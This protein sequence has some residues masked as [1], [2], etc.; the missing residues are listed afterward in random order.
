MPHYSK[1]SSINRRQALSLIVGT[2][3]VIITGCFNARISSRK[4]TID[5]EAFAQ[6]VASGDPTAEGFVLWT[7]RE[8]GAFPARSLVA[9]VAEDAGFQRVVAETTI[10]I[11]QAVDFTVRVLVRSLEPDHL[12]YY[13]FVDDTGRASRT[14]RSF[15]APVPETATTVNFAF[16]SC[17]N[18]GL[19]YCTPYRR[20]LAEDEAKPVAEQLRFILHLGDFIYD[21]VWYPEERTRGF[22]GRK[23]RNFVRFPDGG[24]A[25]E[26]RFPV[27][28]ADYRALYRG[29]LTDPDL[30]AARARWPFVCV[31]D[32]HDFT[33]DAWQSQENYEEARPAQKRKVA[34]NQAWFEY[35][36]ARVLQLETELPGI[37]SR[38]FVAPEVENSPLT[39]ID[40]DGLSR[41]IN[42]L[43]AIDSLRIYRRLRFGRNLDLILTDNRSYR[44]EPA[45]NWAGALQ[46]APLFYSPQDIVEILDAGRTYQPAPPRTIRFAGKDMPNPRA[47]APAGTM[48]GATQKRWFLAQ[49]RDSDATWKL[50]G[51]SLGMLDRRSDL[52]NLPAEK[53]SLWGGTGFGLLGANDWCGYPTER[54][55]IVKFV[56]AEAIA[57]VVSLAGDRHNFFAGSL[58]VSNRLDLYRPVIAEFV[59]SSIT[60]ITSF[61]AAAYIVP[62]TQG[63]TELFVQ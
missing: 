14:G 48:L 1:T 43:R 33:S 46:P 59:V 58:S 32:D 63:P 42:N 12:Y 20:L 54:A 17:Q 38:Y 52:H 49:L 56:A 25:G 15:T 37:Q 60:T 4:A 44:S 9:E 51:N 8:P 61:E 6:G 45:I 24:K 3:T 36:P 35:I 18:V 41:E 53:R 13:R 7:R 28:V 11:E 27:T 31:W 16:V 19:G 5:D 2:G 55:E 22:L 39:A 26:T 23:L 50:W 21:E 34:A 62:R 57:N 47:D 29:Y 30:R 40:E 10:P